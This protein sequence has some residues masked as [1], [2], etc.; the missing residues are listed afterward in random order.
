MTEITGP[1]SAELL[2]ARQASKASVAFG[3]FLS[4]LGIFAVIAPLFAGI[5]VTAL[6]G[7][8]LLAAG[9]AEM[10]FVLQAG[11]FGK[12]V[13]RMVGAGRCSA[14]SCRSSW[15]FSSSRRSPRPARR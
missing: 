7:M 4:V 14:G 2:A 12:G 3:A 15:A 9:I 10:I 13:L 1:G 5:A 6:I 11:S 8:L